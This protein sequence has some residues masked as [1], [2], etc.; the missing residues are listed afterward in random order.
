MWHIL[1]ILGTFDAK[2]LFCFDKQTLEEDIA[3]MRLDII[4]HDCSPAYFFDLLLLLWSIVLGSTLG[5]CTTQPHIPGHP[6]CIFHGFPL[7]S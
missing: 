1:R 2:S 4:I 5:V 3:F 6:G 7:M